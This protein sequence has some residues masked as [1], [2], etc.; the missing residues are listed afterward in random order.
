[1]FSKLRDSRPTYYPSELDKIADKWFQASYFDHYVGYFEVQDQRQL[2]YCSM[3][4]A[5]ARPGPRY[6]PN[7]SDHL[8]T[9]Q[10]EKERKALP[11]NIIPFVVNRMNYNQDFF[12]GLSIPCNWCVNTQRKSFAWF[13]YFT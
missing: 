13:N 1:M 5:L 4:E 11:D 2:S 9:T 12:L 7:Q 3:K 6:A 10:S 8:Q